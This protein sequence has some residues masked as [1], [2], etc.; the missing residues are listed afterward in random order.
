[1]PPEGIPQ[2]PLRHCEGFVNA[3]MRQLQGICTAPLPWVCK[4]SVFLSPPNYCDDYSW[5]IA[6]VTSGAI[7]GSPPISLWWSN[8]W[9][10]YSEWL[11]GVMVGV[12]WKR[13]KT[14]QNCTNHAPR[15]CHKCRSNTLQWYHTFETHMTHSFGLVASTSVKLITKHSDKTWWPCWKTK[16]ET[17]ENTQVELCVLKT[18]AQT[19]Q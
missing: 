19:D 8:V 2:K 16:C 17:A 1:M 14:T 11:H 13:T 9:S 12:I 10:H 3:P 5:V 15:V 6:A 7:H 18:R 4:T